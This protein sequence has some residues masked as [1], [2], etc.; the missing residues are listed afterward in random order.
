MFY[1]FFVC[2]DRAARA[3]NRIIVERL[4]EKYDATPYANDQLGETALHKA[5]RK[6]SD[7]RFYLTKKNPELLFAVDIEG[8]QP[9][10]IAC[11]NNDMN[12]FTWIFQSVLEDLEKNEGNKRNANPFLSLQSTSHIHAP[13]L[14]RFT[15]PELGEA[16]SPDSDSSGFLSKSK[17]AYQEEKLSP[18]SDG[19]KV[20]THGDKGRHQF[21]TRL[22]GH[23]CDPE[24][25]QDPEQP[26]HFPIF[27][28]HHDLSEDSPDS[29]NSQSFILS[30]PSNCA[31]HI[32]RFTFSDDGS[33]GSSAHTFSRP[34]SESSRYIEDSFLYSTSSMVES[35]STMLKETCSSHGDSPL[36]IKDLMSLHMRLFAVNSSGHSVLHIASKNGDWELLHLILQVAKVL[37]HNPDG[38][39]VNILTRRD[40]G[41]TPIEQAIS[42]CQPICLRLLLEFASETPIINEILNDE[43]LLSQAVVSGEL[44]I[45]EVLLEFGMW[46]GLSQAIQASMSGSNQRMLQIVMFYYTQ[47]MSLLRSTRVKHNREVCMDKALVSW[48]ELELEEVRPLWL[49]DATT[50]VTSVAHLLRV[51][52]YHHPIQE[53]HELFAKIGKDC[54]EY[55]KV[56]IWQTMAH[57]KAWKV[58]HITDMNLSS[59]HL[60]SIP[61][62][63]FQIQ[64]LKVLDLSHNR[65]YGLPS[66]LDFQNPLYTCHSLSKLCVNSNRLQTL[67][68]DLF[69]AFGNSLEELHA[70]DNQIEALPPGLWICPRLHTVILGQNKLKQLHYFSDKK[71]F[72][73]QDFS[74]LLIDGIYVD[75]N[76]PMNS[77]KANDEEFMEMM[78]YVT[79]LSIFN[80]TVKALLPEVLEEEEPKDQSSLLQ[81]VIDIHWLRSKLYSDKTATLDYFDVSLPP[82]ETCRLKSLDLSQNL[83]TEFPWDLACIAPNLEKLDFRGNQVKT[84][85]LIKNLPSSIESIV[86]S[87]NKIT[88]ISADHSVAKPCGSPVKLLSGY[89]TDPN[90]TGNCRHT[91]HCILDKATNLNLNNNSLTAFSCIRK[92][93]DGT[94]PLKK[95]SSIDVNP[96]PSLY[97]NLSVLSLDQNNLDAVPEGIHFLS[98]LSSLSLSHNSMISKLPPEMGLMNPQTL[99][100]VKL[101]GVYPKNINQ[102]LLERP[103]ARGILT[104]LKSLHQK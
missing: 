68:E 36:S 35:M 82:D 13:L 95:S 81:H 58:F 77:G 49:K 74:R 63:L 76:V 1:R 104:Y 39:D 8:V 7:L 24:C 66:S 90:L 103:G 21:F 70:N 99:L 73:D 16:F 61:P 83:F 54:V 40:A 86:M 65:L 62:E 29:S 10:H 3:D 11:E 57:P 12:Y 94:K 47:I 4:M 92:T 33:D 18:C 42:S 50:A 80:Q 101:E 96:Y 14:S 60:Q 46:K 75:R 69:F 64:S 28:L 5:C 20:S 27:P 23:T 37:E 19:T 85:N 26:I 88:S 9:L 17:E 93:T 2:S 43:T 6:K 51:G 34:G 30:S 38:A 71:Y 59:N 78:N 32:N 53:N 87:D 45:L 25:F 52:Q 55:F 97:P 89:L 44:K 72:Y 31:T 56:H 98:Q 41:A 102:R 48:E 79:R 15:Q 91:Q 84:L 67:P 22:N 100:I